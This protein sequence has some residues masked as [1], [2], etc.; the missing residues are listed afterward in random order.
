MNTTVIMIIWG[1]CDVLITCHYASLR[2]CFGK[3]IAKNTVHLFVPVFYII[4]NISVL[5]LLWESGKWWYPIVVH[6][7]II[8]PIIQSLPIYRNDF[9]N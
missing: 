8:S 9:D 4:L 6:F 5:V 3:E 7:C 2:A 1:I